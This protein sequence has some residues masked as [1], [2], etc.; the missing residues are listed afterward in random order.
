METDVETRIETPQGILGKYRLNE[1][2]KIPAGSTVR[3]EFRD[4]GEMML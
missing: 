4:N 1:K 2:V 3:L